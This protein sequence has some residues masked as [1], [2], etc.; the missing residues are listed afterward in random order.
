M[1]HDRLYTAVNEPEL[2]V[3]DRIVFEKVGAYTMCLTPLFIRYFPDVYVYDGQQMRKVRN[4]WTAE[5]YVQ[6]SVWDKE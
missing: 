5:E 4:A 3:G 2:S 1:E 6:K